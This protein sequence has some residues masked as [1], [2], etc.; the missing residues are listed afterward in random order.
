MQDTSGTSRKLILYN[1]ILY[2]T[3]I[4]TEKAFAD[5][6]PELKEKKKTT[7]SAKYLKG[8]HLEKNYSD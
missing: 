2:I 4:A 6:Q 1:R 5:S 7:T 8:Q 3:R